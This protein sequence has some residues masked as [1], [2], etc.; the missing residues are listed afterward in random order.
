[1]SAITVRLPNSVHGEAKQLAPA[2]GVSIKNFI[3]S[4]VA[5]KIAARR[6]VGWLKKQAGA[7]GSPER[8]LAILAEAPDVPPMAGDELPAPKIKRRK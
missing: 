3:V 2:D 4:A 8:L 6:T 1:M 7:H 5:E